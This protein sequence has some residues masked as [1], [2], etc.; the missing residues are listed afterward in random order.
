[1]DPR[2][3]HAKIRRD[4]LGSDTRVEDSDSSQ[5]AKLV[6]VVIGTGP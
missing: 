2:L 6:E 3:R 5:A 1:M 4:G